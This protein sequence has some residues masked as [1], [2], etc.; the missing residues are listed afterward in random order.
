[1]AGFFDIV[2][3]NLFWW[4]CPAPWL[5]GPYGIA[6]AQTALGGAVA[7]NVAVAGAVAGEVF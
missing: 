6:A 7:G 5:G 2:R 4:A 1:M 3:K